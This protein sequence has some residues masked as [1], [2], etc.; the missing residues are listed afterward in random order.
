MKQAGWLL[1]LPLSDAK[2][3]RLLG[4]APSLI[5]Q[6]AGD[7]GT[8]D[9]R[10]AVHLARLACAGD[11]TAVSVPKVEDEAIRGRSRARE[12]TLSDLNAAQLRLKAFLLRHDI[13]STGR[14]H[15]SPAHRRWLSAVVCPTPAQPI[16]F[17]AYVRAVNAHTARLQRL[18]QA[19]Q[20]QGKSWRL[21]PVVEALQAL[22][23]GQSTVAVT[24]VA[25]L[26]A[27][28]RVEPPREL[29][30]CLGLLPAA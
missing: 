14:A 9:R 26:G 25:A 30:Q 23:G 29:R 27:L 11:L 3:L 5:P 13:R 24:P 20:E 1:A 21:P 2:R 7:R 12:D 4:G 17:Q 18:A 6:K 8:T 15:W 10:D 16:V 28:T 22:R 19:L